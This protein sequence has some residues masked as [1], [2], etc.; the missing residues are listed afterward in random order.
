VVIKT[1]PPG[2]DI[3]LDGRKQE[4]KSPTM[5]ARLPVDKPVVVLCMKDGL[6]KRESVTLTKETPRKTLDLKLEK[7]K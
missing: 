2:A 5:I 3:Y 6:E 4:S 7:K 1:T